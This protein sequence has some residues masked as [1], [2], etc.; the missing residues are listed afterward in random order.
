MIYTW[1]RLTEILLLQMNSLLFLYT[2]KHWLW[3]YSI[4][5][6][7][8]LVNLKNNHKEKA[9]NIEL[10]VK[11]TPM[12]LVLFTIFFFFTVCFFFPTFQD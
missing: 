10:L 6:Q 8:F 12:I 9:S 4:F 5:T 7:K 1:S 11:C 3:N 2:E